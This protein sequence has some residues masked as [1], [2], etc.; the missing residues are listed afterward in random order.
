MAASLLVTACNKHE[1]TNAGDHTSISSPKIYTYEA[2]LLLEDTAEDGHTWNVVILREAL[3]RSIQRDTKTDVSET[4]RMLA[5]QFFVL[6]DGRPVNRDQIIASGNEIS[7]LAKV[8]YFENA[9][10]L[11]GRMDVPKGWEGPIFA[12]SWER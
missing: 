2:F 9:S 10:A 5:G 6:R 8:N 7:R 3:V 4:A 11:F 1:G 12:V